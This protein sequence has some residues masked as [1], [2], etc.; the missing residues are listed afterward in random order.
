M[1]GTAKRIDYKETFLYFDDGDDD[2]D[3][4]L[5]RDFSYFDDGDDDDDGAL[6][7]ELI[8]KRLFSILMMAMR[9]LMKASVMSP[10]T[11]YL[12]TIANEQ[13]PTF[14]MCFNISTVPT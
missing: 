8:A 5:Q 4:A 14:M 2:D 6:Q 12:E 13:H 7:R 9:T 11:F 3:G 10:E 1:G